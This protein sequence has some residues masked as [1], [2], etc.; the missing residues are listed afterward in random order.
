M[1]IM[2]YIIHAKEYMGK[3]KIVVKWNVLPSQYERWNITKNAE[4]PVYLSLTVPPS[5][6]LE[7]PSW[8]NVQLV[9]VEMTIL[10]VVTHC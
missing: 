1:I 10:E 9:H 3:L 4:F 5:T 8:A 2:T 7:V 6:P